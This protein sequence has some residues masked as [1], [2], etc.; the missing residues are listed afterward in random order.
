MARNRRK[1]REDHGSEGARKRRRV[2]LPEDT[3]A[4]MLPAKSQIVQDE[5]SVQVPPQIVQVRE[6][7]NL[8]RDLQSRRSL[9]GRRKKDLKNIW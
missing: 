1:E 9:R 3:N 7:A 6:V 4:E 8:R 5:V 2:I